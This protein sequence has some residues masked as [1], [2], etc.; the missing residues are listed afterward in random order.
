MHGTEIEEAN[1]FNDLV[2]EYTK[3]NKKTYRLLQAKHKLKEHYKITK[4][5]LLSKKYII[6]YTNIDWDFENLK[7]ANIE[8]EKIEDEDDI[9][10]MEFIEKQSARYMFKSNVISLLKN[11]IEKYNR[12]NIKENNINYKINE[13]EDFL[14]HL[15]FA[16]N[17]PNQEELNNIIQK[18]I[19]KS[20]CLIYIK[21]KIKMKTKWNKICC[22]SHFGHFGE[23]NKN[24]LIRKN[25]EE[26][27]NEYDDK[28]IWTNAETYEVLP[29]NSSSMKE[30]LTKI[31]KLF[32]EV[33]IHLG[34]II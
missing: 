9:L 1:A 7:N 33:D 22:V 15:V 8:I 23:I 30:M 5:E 34:Y 6:I 25:I 20:N 28:V 27:S 32:L 3:D 21:Y 12:E 18:E 17:Q 11:T 31:L 2:F 29:M 4:H 16:V 26:Y 10:D 13:I 14:N 24:E 19:E